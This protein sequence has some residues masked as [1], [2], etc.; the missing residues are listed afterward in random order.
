MS[1]CCGDSAHEHQSHGG[2]H[3][4]GGIVLQIEGMTCS[5]CQMRVEKAL[6]SVPGVESAHVDLA[7]KQAVVTGIADRSALVTAVEEA[8]YSVAA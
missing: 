8:G 3:P 5:H 7:K 4:G 2:A 1:R 6:K